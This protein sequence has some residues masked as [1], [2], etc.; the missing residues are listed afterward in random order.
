MRTPELEGVSDAR[1]SRI[2]RSRICLKANLGEEITEVVT[3]RAKLPRGF[4]ECLV[5]DFRTAYALVSHDDLAGRDADALWVRAR[6]NT[7]AIKI[8]QKVSVPVVKDVVVTVVAGKSHG[9]SSRIV[10]MPALLRDVF[11]EREYAHGVVLG[12]PDDFGIVLR[13]LDDLLAVFGIGTAGEFTA[14]AYD[15]SADG[16]SPKLYWWD[17]EIFH[18]IT[19]VRDNGTVDP[20]TPAKLVAA[21]TSLAESSPSATSAT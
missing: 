17:G 3:S 4:V 10:D 20:V 5:A 21:I 9:F 18:T 13:P 19:R 6:S 15:A 11:G 7:A 2:V 16:F 14:H 1:L 12:I 8:V